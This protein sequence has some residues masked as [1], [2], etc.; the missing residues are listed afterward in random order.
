MRRIRYS[1]PVK[2]LYD[3]FN[4]TRQRRRDIS[5]TLLSFSLF[6]I[7]L[8]V[9]TGAPISKFSEK[10]GAGDFFYSLLIA[11]PVLG[12]A[13]QIFASVILERTK[14]RKSLFIICGLI[15]RAS[16]IIIGLIPLIVPSGSG[17]SPIY[18]I[19]LFMII[20]SLTNSMLGVG[21]Y[22]WIGDLMPRGMMGRYYGLRESIGTMV[23]L[24]TILFVS[25]YLD[26]HSSFEAFAII[27]AVAGTAGILDI[28]G[29]IFVTDVPMNSTPHPPVKDFIK[30]AFS[31]HAFRKYI[32]F[33]SLLSLTFNMSAGFYNLYGLTHL[34]LSFMQVAV[35]G[36]IAF[37][38]VTF[39][40]A[41]KWGNALDKSGIRP[42]M[43]R[44]GIVSSIIPMI[45]LF[46]VPG[47]MWTY[48]VFS[49][50][51]GLTLTAVSTTAQK[52][53]T[54]VIPETNRTMYI[55]L[56][57]VTTSIFAVVGFLSGGALLEILGNTDFSIVFIRFDRYKILFSA[58]GLLRLAVI[59][60]V[61]PLMTKSMEE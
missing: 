1:G 53:L 29:F 28:L 11:L 21:F 44:A 8:P 39:F 26:K 4:L 24:T 36:Q 7:Y 22:S 59:L 50:F 14:K 34:E 37:S 23:T 27:F 25:L 32:I 49:L 45:M 61:M 6:Y 5:F 41:P 20:S 58:S 2:S 13:L 30:T 33:W 47:N 56:Y 55:A 35:A 10:L 16:W 40:A 17:I 52:M 19:L 38:S 42:V 46:S 18:W 9:I 12:N 60:F 54:G 43:L 48:V 3:S 51:N 31:S 15:S 57:S